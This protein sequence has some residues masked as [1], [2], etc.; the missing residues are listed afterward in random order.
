MKFDESKLKV[1]QSGKKKTDPPG[2]SGATKTEHIVTALH[3]PGPRPKFGN[4]APD[5]EG[6]TSSRVAKLRC[7]FDFVQDHCL[8]LQQRRSRG[9]AGPGMNET[10]WGRGN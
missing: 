3:P 4:L 8:G 2:R 10:L 6:A 7:G 9:P 1:L 5:S